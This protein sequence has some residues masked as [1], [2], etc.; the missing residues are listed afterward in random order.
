MRKLQLEEKQKCGVQE[1]FYGKTI[2]VCVCVCVYNFW[3][4]DNGFLV[5]VEFKFMK[6]RCMLH[7]NFV[8]TLIVTLSKEIDKNK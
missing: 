2:S 1:R 5:R 4:F 8:K 3:N 7:V 6:F